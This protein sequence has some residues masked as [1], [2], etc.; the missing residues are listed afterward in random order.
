MFRRGVRGEAL[1]TAAS[2]T[3]V[4]EKSVCSS[5]STAD[6]DA[7]KARRGSS[8]PH[9]GPLGNKRMDSH[10]A[11]QEQRCV[12]S[13]LTRSSSTSCTLLPHAYCD[14]RMMTSRASVMP[15]NLSPFLFVAY[16]SLRRYKMK[17]CLSHHVLIAS[18]VKI[19]LL[20]KSTLWLFLGVQF[21]EVFFVN[22][23]TF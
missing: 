17:R 18:L 3:A 22:S 19:S 20:A 2:T 21:F 13:V 11:A 14:T 9:C 8:G 12:G 5:Y 1:G 4:F 7:L 23:W 10:P 15:Q 6:T 16:E